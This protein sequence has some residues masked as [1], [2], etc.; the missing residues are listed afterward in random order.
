MYTRS[1]ANY[2]SY[3]NYGATRTTENITS[4][5]HGTTLYAQNASGAGFEG[6]QST[7]VSPKKCKKSCFCF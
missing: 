6:Y 7:A 1:N 3:T 2:S 5:I 4:S